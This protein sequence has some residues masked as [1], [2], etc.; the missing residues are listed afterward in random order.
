[1]KKPASKPARFKMMKT[2]GP[3]A[4]GNAIGDFESSTDFF[5]KFP[6]FCF[7]V[8]VFPAFSRQ[9]WVAPTKIGMESY[10]TRKHREDRL[11]IKM[12]SICT[13]I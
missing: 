6:H 11:Q 5:S 2:V 13:L 3:K 7:K 12:H 10:H 8:S 4:R 1:M 9:N